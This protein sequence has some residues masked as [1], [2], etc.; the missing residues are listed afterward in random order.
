MCLSLLAKSSPLIAMQLRKF[1]ASAL[2]LSGLASAVNLP[3]HEA[4]DCL[5]DGVKCNAYSGPQCCA[6]YC[7]L[8]NVSVAINIV[9][10]L[11]LTQLW[12][13][14]LHDCQIAPT[15][16]KLSLMN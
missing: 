3:R 2:L 6:G 5:G 11:L 12:R 16:H 15:G 10:M 7:N 1:I 9:V 4:D 13:I 14:D 8:G